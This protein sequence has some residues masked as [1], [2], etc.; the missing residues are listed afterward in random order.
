MPSNVKALLALRQNPMK[1]K[2][3]AIGKEEY[4]QFKMFALYSL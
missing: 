4:I 1:T 2:T 3:R